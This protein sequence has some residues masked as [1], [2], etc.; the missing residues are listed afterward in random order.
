MAQST[1]GGPLAS[2]YEHRI[3]DATNSNEVMGYWVFLVGVVLGFL[4]LLTYYTTAPATMR[5]RRRIR[6]RGA[7]TGAPDVRCSPPVPAP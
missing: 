6:A 7:G 4:G 3:G 1:K 5:P 2:I